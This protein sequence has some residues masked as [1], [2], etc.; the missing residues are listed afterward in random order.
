MTYTKNIHLENVLHLILGFTFGVWALHFDFQKVS[1]IQYY[2]KNINQLKIY[3]QGL[4]G[5]FMVKK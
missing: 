4:M 5:I 3:I 2:F 1:A